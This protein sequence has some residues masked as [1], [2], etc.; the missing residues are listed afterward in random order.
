MVIAFFWY[1][2]NKKEK[3]F[4]E[5][6]DKTTLNLET[7][8]ADDTKKDQKVS[9]SRSLSSAKSSAEMILEVSRSDSWMISSK[10]IE[11]CKDEDGDDF[12]LGKGGYGRVVKA[13]KGGVQEVALKIMDS[14]DPGI[15]EAC[16]QEAEIMKL[17]HDQNIVHL[18][19]ICRENK[20]L[21]VVMEYMGGGDLA[22][23]IVNPKLRHHF[24]WG[25]HGKKI[26]LDIIKGLCY[27]HSKSMLHRDIKTQNILLDESKTLAKI[28]D[29]GVSRFLDGPGRFTVVGTLVYIA[30][31]ILRREPYDLKA[32]IYSFGVVRRSIVQ[33]SR[34]IWQSL[35][36]QL[37]IGTGLEGAH[38]TTTSHARGS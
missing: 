35:T 29:V 17:L 4:L 11:I 6:A 25:K 27:L 36:S 38:N 20:K 13:I 8:K 9:D 16:I 3:Q 26:A 23:S 28:G 15:R 12:L 14:K 22:K 30:P 31:E 32:D 18:Y 21:Y 24:S 2:H 37:L 5:N 10:D 33:V 7:G 1:R 19:G 34:H